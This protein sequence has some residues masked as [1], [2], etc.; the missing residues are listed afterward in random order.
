MFHRII[1]VCNVP[2]VSW[3]QIFMDFVKFLFQGCSKVFTTVEARF[4]PEHY[5]IKWVGNR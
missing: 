1:V 5:V 2:H 3:D 4:N